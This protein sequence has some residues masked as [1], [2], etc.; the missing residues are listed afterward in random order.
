MITK[1]DFGVS[2]VVAPAYLLHL[3]V[4]QFLPFFTF[5]MSGYVFQAF[6]LIFVIIV[7]RRFRP[8]FLL[9]F[10]TAVIYGFIL[11]G[12]M[13]LMSLI[14]EV[15]LP[16]RI[17]LYILGLVFSS[18]GVSFMFH[19][20]ISPEVYELLVKEFTEK[21]GFKMHNVKTFYDCSSCVLA[22]ILS[23]CFFGFGNFEGVSWGTVVCALVNGVL[24]GMVS[25]FLDKRYE[26]VDRFKLRK[27]F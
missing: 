17:V 8:A 9:S 7:V 26:F 1:A 19:T 20:Y 10:L 16:I 23:F 24:V 6:L 13:A 21:F 11:D 15:G 27:Y 2:M 18:I 3:K 4:S 22:V 14:G 25:R 5:G 12:G